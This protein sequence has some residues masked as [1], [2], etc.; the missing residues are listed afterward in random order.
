MQ[1]IGYLMLVA[2][3]VLYFLYKVIE[4]SQYIPVR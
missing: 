3:P 2:I 4:L 1:A